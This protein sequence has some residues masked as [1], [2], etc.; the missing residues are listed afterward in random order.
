MSRLSPTG[1]VMDCSSWMNTSA[2]R[3][4]FH[5]SVNAKIADATSPGAARGSSTRRN[6]LIRPAP[7]MRAASS[8]S[9]G[10]AL[11][12]PISSQVAKGTVKVG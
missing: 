5:D 1:T 4:S 3:N 6:A 7:S 8:S 11:K 2:Y 9:S 12:K 10:S